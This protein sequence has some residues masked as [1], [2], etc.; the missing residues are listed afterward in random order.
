MN[1]LYIV[2]G[3][4]KKDVFFAKQDPGMARQNSYARAGRN[5]LQPHTNI[6]R[7]LCSLQNPTEI[8]KLRRPYRIEAFIHNNGGM[9]K[10]TE[11][12]PR[13]V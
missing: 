3:T 4:R 13:D 8:W 9:R 12:F 2:Q 10:V 7:V 6:F 1:L 11:I 5:F